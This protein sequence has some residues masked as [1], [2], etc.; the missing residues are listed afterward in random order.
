MVEFEGT[1]FHVIRLTYLI[2]KF[3]GFAKWTERGLVRLSKEWGKKIEEKWS[4]FTSWIFPLKLTSADL[5]CD[6]YY[7]MQ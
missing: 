5:K 6:P 4:S 7:K 2:W 3:V 1:Q